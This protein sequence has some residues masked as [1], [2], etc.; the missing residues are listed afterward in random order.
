MF[1]KHHDNQ[2]NDRKWKCSVIYISTQWTNHV[3]VY[4][5]QGKKFSS[6][7]N[8]K[9]L[10]QQKVWMATQYGKPLW[11][12]LAE[13]SASSHC[14]CKGKKSFIYSTRQLEGCFLRRPDVALSYSAH[15]MM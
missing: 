3:Q 2:A 10:R 4:K 8:E 1:H 13:F 12:A 14:N 7:A 5:V 6:F 9:C 11:E 15:T